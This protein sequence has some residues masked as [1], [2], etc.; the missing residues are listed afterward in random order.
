[1]GLR[2]QERVQ[3]DYGEESQEPELD[4]TMDDG[5]TDMGGG[6]FL[7]HEEEQAS[8]LVLEDH[9]PAPPKQKEAAQYPTPMSMSSNK[10]KT[11]RKSLLH[12]DL[13]SAE[14]SDL[15]SAP[16]DPSPS[17]FNATEED[18]ESEEDNAP[19]S[20]TRARRAKGRPK[21][22]ATPKTTTTP[23]RG[24]RKSARAAITSPYF[25]GHDDAD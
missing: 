7:P 5:G 21:K 24:L 18:E 17:K 3:E 4:A 10:K 1:M 12:E 9:E 6:F 15:S 2:I 14:L 25:E 13:E 11:H 20:K 16:E 23:R 19:R 22:E 8:E